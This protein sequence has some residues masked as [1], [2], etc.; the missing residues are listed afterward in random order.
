MLSKK[1]EKRLGAARA[2]ELV[3]DP[4]RRA[5]LRPA[6]LFSMRRV[7]GWTKNNPTCKCPTC[8]GTGFY[9]EDANSEHEVTCETCLG[10]GFI[11][12]GELARLYFEMNAEYRIEVVE[13]KR[14]S[15]VLSRI[16]RKLD[17]Y[18]K[19]FLG[20]TNWVEDKREGSDHGRG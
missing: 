19:R 9:P 6:S 3:Y 13:W 10:D 7:S 8:E 14:Y 20:L 15:R 11:S 12:E 1:I 18:E 5:P 4:S 16:K 2:S 17:N